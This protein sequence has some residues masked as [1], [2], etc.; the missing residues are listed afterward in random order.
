MVPTNEILKH[1]QWIRIKIKIHVDQEPT[2]C[3]IQDTVSPR[4]I[5]ERVSIPIFSQERVEQLIRKLHELYKNL[6]KISVTRQQST[7]FELR[8]ATSNQCMK[9]LFAI[10]ACKCHPISNCICDTCDVIFKNLRPK[11]SNTQL[12]L[13]IS[14]CIVLFYE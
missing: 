9:Q 2:I 7:A 12:P 14:I 6:T 1:Y 8:I 4:V 5:G 10:T 13:T 3:E 11:G